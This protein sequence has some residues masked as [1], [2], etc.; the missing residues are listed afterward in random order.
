[1]PPFFSCRSKQEVTKPGAGLGAFR[2]LLVWASLNAPF[3][4]RATARALLYCCYRRCLPR[5]LSPEVFCVQPLRQREGLL[6]RIEESSGVL[7]HPA[8]A[9]RSGSEEENEVA[10]CRH[11][12]GCR[13]LKVVRIGQDEGNDGISRF[14]GLDSVR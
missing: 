8:F 2:G 11:H 5:E 6:E 9:G 12:V 13:G 7:R 1:M 3:F 4:L 10:E 14:G